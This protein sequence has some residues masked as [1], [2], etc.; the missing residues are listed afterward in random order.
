MALRLT[1]QNNGLSFKNPKTVTYT[2]FI[3]KQNIY[4][5][6][7]SLD[8]YIVGNLTVGLVSSDKQIVLPH[9]LAITNLEF[10]Q[11]SKH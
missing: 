8:K 7:L 1:F 2:N 4:S 3:L 6:D 10:T 11:F 5:W 9:S